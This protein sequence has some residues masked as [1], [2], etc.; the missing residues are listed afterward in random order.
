MSNWHS[1]KMEEM[2]HKS[3]HS[4]RFIIE[5]CMEAAKAAKSLGNEIAEGRYL[6]EMHYASME[7]R[8]RREKSKRRAY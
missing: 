4:L 8:A 5:D 7:L 2:K 3:E 6:D 1:D